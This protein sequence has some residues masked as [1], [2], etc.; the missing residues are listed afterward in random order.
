MANAETNKEEITK[1]TEQVKIQMDEGTSLK[2]AI[3]DIDAKKKSVV[4]YD[5]RLIEPTTSQNFSTQDIVKPAY[6]A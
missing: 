6:V 4:F 1:L 5:M 3:E 2:K